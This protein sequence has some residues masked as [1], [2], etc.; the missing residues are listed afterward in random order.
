ML[1]TIEEEIE[2]PVEE[3]CGDFAVLFRSATCFSLALNV[4]TSKDIEIFS[5]VYR[6]VMHIRVMDHCR[7]GE[8]DRR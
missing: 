4:V 1:E 3:E 6:L 8:G 2:E 5:D 7:E